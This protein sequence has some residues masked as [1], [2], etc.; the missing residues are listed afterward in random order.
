MGRYGHIDQR[1]NFQGEK[2]TELVPVSGS[3]LGTSLIKRGASHAGLSCTTNR[4][5]A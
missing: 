3:V 2:V 5:A 4:S 1:T